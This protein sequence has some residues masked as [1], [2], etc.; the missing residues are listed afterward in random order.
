M[1][2]TP[3][4]DDI[5]EIILWI[6]VFLESGLQKPRF[7]GAAPAARP[8]AGTMPSQHF[9]RLI[10]IMA[11]L[12]GP[13]GCPWDR[14]QTIQTLRR[15]LIEEAYEVL[16]AMER[17]DWPH[18]AEELG[19][20]QLQIVFQAQIAAEDGN[21]TIEDVLSAINEKLVRRHPHVF[22]K[23]SAAT[24]QEVLRRW[25]QIKAEEAAAKRENSGSGGDEPKSLLDSVP[26]A[27]P[28][29]IE[30]YRIGK[31]AAAIGFDWKN[32]EDL[33]AKLEEETQE[34][35]QARQSPE[36]GRGRRVEEELGDLL[37]MAVNAARH[38]KIDPEQ[39]LRN[40]NRKFRERFRHIENRLRQ[41]G[42]S[43]DETNLEEMEGLWR[44]AKHPPTG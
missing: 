32:P 8:A 37:F 21:F 34:L 38:F 31:A 15:Y 33:Q 19:D 40:A 39:A 6:R 23:E 10:D 27:Q 12:R 36:E 20:L 18:L 16:D 7:L 5:S 30:A 4:H 2:L 14:E 24:P 26:R 3:H 25:E 1:G 42:R 13:D 44:E 17:E 35:E 29:L 11:R 43:F 28:A 41:Q 22:A 9:Q